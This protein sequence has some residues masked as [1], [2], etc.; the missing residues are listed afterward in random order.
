MTESIPAFA[1]IRYFSNM[2]DN[3][4][5][6]VMEVEDMTADLKD[7]SSYPVGSW[8]FF[9]CSTSLGFVLEWFDQHI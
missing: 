3:P 7:L 1:P 2:A 5:E 4:P 6:E 8:A 9:L